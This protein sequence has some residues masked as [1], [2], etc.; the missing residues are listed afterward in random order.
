MASSCSAA[1]KDLPAACT[2]PSAG[3]SE[4]AMSDIAENAPRSVRILRTPE[5]EDASAAGE[6][7][8]AEDAN[9]DGNESVV[10]LEAD[11]IQRLA[12]AWGVTPILVREDLATQ[13]PDISLRDWLRDKL[14]DNEDPKL[15]VMADGS[16]ITPDPDAP[17]VEAARSSAPS[18]ESL[19]IVNGWEIAR[20]S[21]A[22]QTRDQS[23]ESTSSRTL[24]DK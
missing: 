19:P 24:A 3:A 6:S 10:E 15:C 2:T 21:F 23:W 7:E 17:E 16:I 9:L 1:R 20:S 18:S 22:L 11:R 13:Q 8:A 12:A 4:N 5:E 14:R